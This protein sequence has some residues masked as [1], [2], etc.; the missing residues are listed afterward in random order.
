[1]IFLR[2]IIKKIV[3]IEQNMLGRWNLDNCGP[4]GKILFKKKINYNSNG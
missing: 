1:M 3:K 4:C 2:L